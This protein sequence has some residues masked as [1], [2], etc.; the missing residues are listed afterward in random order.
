MPLATLIVTVAVPAPWIVARPSAS[1]VSTFVESLVLVTAPAPTV[2]TP[3]NGKSGSP[4]VFV[5]GHSASLIVI[6][7][8]A[9]LI[10]AVALEGMLTW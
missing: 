1:T 10:V 6:E 4:Y 7:D 9:F 8:A 5:P 3:V 2:V